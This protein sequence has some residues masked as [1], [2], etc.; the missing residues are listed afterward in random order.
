MSRG[1][2]RLAG[3]AQNP[4]GG[5]DGKGVLV[6]ESAGDARERAASWFNQLE[7]RTDF[8]SLLAEEKVPFTRE[9]SALVARRESGQVIPLACG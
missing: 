3:G 6:L 4:R 1:C 9:L 7:S 2:D 5:Y 8:S